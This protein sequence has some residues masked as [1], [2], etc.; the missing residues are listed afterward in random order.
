M[1]QGQQTF[2]I[3]LIVSFLLSIAYAWFLEQIHDTYSPNWIWL[4]VVIGNGA[5]IDT[6]LILERQLGIVVDGRMLFL[7]NLA[8]GLPIV[9]WQLWQWRERI[10][11]NDAD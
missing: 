8:W 7:I 9:A 6:V 1:S 3:V 2:V 11:Q 5:I 10:R 4:T